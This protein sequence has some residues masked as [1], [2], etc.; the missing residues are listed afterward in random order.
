VEGALLEPLADGVVIL[1]LLPS[2]S[3]TNSSRREGL[4]SSRTLYDET[5]ISVVD[6]LAL[7]RQQESRF[8][9]AGKFD[10]ESTGVPCFL[11]ESWTSRRL[12]RL[13]SIQIRS[14]SDASTDEGIGVEH[15]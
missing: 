10:C 14:G 12:S 15:P 5:S 3:S 8:F 6:P 1:Y 11:F 7:V 2:K 4:M 13:I 9:I